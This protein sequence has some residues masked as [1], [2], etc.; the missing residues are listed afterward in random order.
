MTHNEFCAQYMIT[1]Q[2]GRLYGR[3]ML[4]SYWGRSG[5]YQILRDLGL[6]PYARARE[7]VDDPTWMS[8]QAGST[9]A[10]VCRALFSHILEREH[11]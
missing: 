7:L 5:G 11:A 10:S 1:S 4:L 2:R 6:D 8:I 3:Q 9:P